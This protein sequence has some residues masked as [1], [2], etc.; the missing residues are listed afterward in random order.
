[1]PASRSPSARR[2]AFSSACRRSRTCFPASPWLRAPAALLVASACAEI[3]LLP[4]GAFVFSRITFAGLLVNFAAIPLM[5]LV[6]IAGMA[7]VGLTSVSN[8]ARAMGRM[9]RA[10]CGRGAHRQ[11]G[12]RRCLALADAPA[13]ASV[14]VGHGRVLRVAHRSG[15]CHIR[16]AT[17]EVRGCAA[18]RPWCSWSAASG[19]SPRQRLRRDRPNRCA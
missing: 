2:S 11:R 14:A 15:V 1:M 10:P 7:A 9:D 5:T 19:L 6:Q 12:A 8:R 16:S 17:L 3:A 18:R 13:R 4:I